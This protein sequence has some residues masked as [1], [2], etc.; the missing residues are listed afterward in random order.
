MA[1]TVE[2]GSKLIQAGAIGA[3]RPVDHG[4]PDLVPH[5]PRTRTK[6]N[7][8]LGFFDAGKLC[9]GDLPLVMQRDH[10]IQH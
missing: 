1:S 10:G 7:D 6:A 9:R 4:G 5:K 8:R 3:E 2:Q